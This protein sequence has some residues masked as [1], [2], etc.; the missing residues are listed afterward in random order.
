MTAGTGGAPPTVEDIRA[1]GGIPRHVA[2]IMDGNGRWASE[3]GLPR[4]RGHRE[5]MQSVRVAVE[6]ALEVGLEHLSLYAFSR[7][8]WSRPPREVSALMRLLAEFV[9]RERE[10]LREQGVRTRVFGDRERLPPE[11]LASVERLESTTA[12]G[13]N[14]QL[15][16]A[17]SYG[18]RDE[19]TTAARRVAELAARGAL[20]PSELGPD[21]FA[22]HLYTAGWPDPDLLVRTSGEMRIS[23]FLL[24]QIAYS[25]I[26][27]TPVLW[28]DFRRSDFLAAI[29]E[30]QRRDRRFGR[31]ST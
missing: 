17:I 1:A 8:N 29:A 27:V 5:G 12:G 9:D 3:R 15:N 18:A 23:N 14:L 13:A 7:E 26:H 24:W 11:A 19:I 30:F 10:E 2:I 4:W 22:S 21:E 16:V 6:S 20:D 28:P 25:E 31:V